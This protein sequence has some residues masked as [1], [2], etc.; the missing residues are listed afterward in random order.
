MNKEEIIEDLR[1]EIAENWSDEDRSAFY[2]AVYNDT[3]LINLHHSFGTYI[4]NKYKLWTIP[5]EPELRDGTD[6]SPDHPDQ[7]SMTIIEELWKRG[8]LKDK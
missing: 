5:W 3:S 1:K 8:P 6:Y 7:I 2:L 4:R